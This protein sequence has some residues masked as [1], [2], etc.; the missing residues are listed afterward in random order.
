MDQNWAADHLQVI[1]TLMER[2][3]LYRR[4]MAPIMLVSGVLG[5]L[6]ALVALRLVAVE[7]PAEF[8]IYWTGVGVLTLGVALVLVRRQALKAAESFWSTPTQRVAAGL[9]P[10]FLSGLAVAVTAV[11]NS[12]LIPVWL[13]ACLW[14]LHYGCALQAAGFFMQRGIKLFGA[15]FLFGGVLLLAGSSNC[16]WLRSPGTGHALMG[17]F[18]GGFHLAYGAYLYFTERKSAA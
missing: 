10:C 16:P 1:R 2:S 15:L 3:A 12:G 8:T 7:S 6:G 17:A 14:I 18:F 11:L 5:S 13:L 4:A 9:F